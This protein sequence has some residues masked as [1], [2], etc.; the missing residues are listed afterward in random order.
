MAER[1]H[2]GACLCGQFRWSAEGDPDFQGF[3]HCDHCRRISGAGRTPFLGFDAV[4]V[5]VEGQTAS[6][7]DIAQNGGRIDRH[8]CAT[9]GARAYSIPGSAPG[10]RIFY[11]GSLGTPDRFAPAVAI[12][13]AS[14][15]PWDP[16][17]PGL[18]DFPGAAPD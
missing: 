10:F 2:F 9:C 13:T 15:V 7:A 18:P 17:E 3:C 16:V 5:T 8:F 12:H 1:T 6:Y 4:R 14:A 11:A